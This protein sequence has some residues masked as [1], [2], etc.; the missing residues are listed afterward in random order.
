MIIIGSGGFINF[1]KLNSHILGYVHFLVSG[2]NSSFFNL[3]HKF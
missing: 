1:E 2:I 3:T